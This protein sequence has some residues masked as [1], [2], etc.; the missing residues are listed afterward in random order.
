MKYKIIIREVSSAHEIYFTDFG[1]LPAKK[2]QGQGQRG[3]REGK[4]VGFLAAIWQKRKGGKVLRVQSAR[5]KRKVYV[6][7]RAR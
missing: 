7:K 1:Y 2:G 6:L 5:V 3:G 4:A